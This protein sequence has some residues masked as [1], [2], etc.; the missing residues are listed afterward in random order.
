MHGTLTRSWIALVLGFAAAAAPAWAQEQEPLVWVAPGGGMVRLPEQLTNDRDRPSVGG[1]LGIRLVPHLALEGRGHHAKTGGLAV[2]HGEGNLTW[3][4]TWERRVA[5]YLTAGAG[6]LRQA[7]DN[8]LALNGGG[9]LRVA[10]AGKVALRLDVRDVS[11]KLADAGGE[12]K[13]RH[14]I[15]AFGG[16]SFGL[17]GKPRDTDLDGIPDK[18]D[19]CPATPAGARVDSRGCPIDGDGDGVPDGIDQCAATP[20]GCRVDRNGCPSDEDADG[21]CDGSDKCPGTPSGCLVDVTGCP[22][23]SDG[24]GVCE[25]LDRCAG[26]AKGCRVD[27]KGCPLDAD[28]DGVC[29]GLDQGPDTPPSARVDRRG[30]PIVVSEKETEL[31]DTGMIRLQNVNFATGK[32]DIDVDSYPVLDEVGDILLRWPELR[33]EIGGH[34][35]SR[36]SAEMNLALSEARAQA[37]MDYLVSA[38]PELQPEQ[39]TAMGYGETKPIADNATE[40]GRAKNRRVEFRVLNTDVLKR[41]KEKQTIL[42]R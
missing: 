23:D 41:E 27:A 18:R 7:R 20:R 29:D 36:G 21:V 40:L 15:E 11:F 9:G 5:P 38:F 2:N 28:G 19:A 12:E 31:L 42:P 37:V 33:V 17:G 24:D 32:A 10:L 30:C 16:L 14:T 34:T 25:G 1:I 6:V 3:F 4:L 22:L 13:Y 8:R 35:D 26:T 39:F